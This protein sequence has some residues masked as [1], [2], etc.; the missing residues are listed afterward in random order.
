MACHPE[1]KR[2]LFP[3]AADARTSP[4]RSRTFRTRSRVGET[5]GNTAAAGRLYG[6][7]PEPP[8][9]D[10]TQPRCGRKLGPR[11]E[12]PVYE[13]LNTAALVVVTPGPTGLPSLPP[14]S[15]SIARSVSSASSPPMR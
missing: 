9:D 8:P 12:L 3:Q 13:A 2:S 4:G 1:I 5:G 6:T 14:N 10:G 15:T 11:G 7:G